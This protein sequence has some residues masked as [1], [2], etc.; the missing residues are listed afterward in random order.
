MERFNGGL[1]AYWKR[2]GA[3][4]RL[5]TP[6]GRR[7]RRRRVDRAELGEGGWRGVRIRTR[8]WRRL[9]RATPRRILAWI[10]DAYV[11]MMLALASSATVG[12]AYGVGFGMAP[13]KEYY[14]EKVLVEIYR[15]VLARRG[16]LAVGGART[17]EVLCCLKMAAKCI[18]GALVGTLVVAYVCDTVISDKK[19]FGGTTPKTISDKEWWEATD[20]KFQ[21]W[22]RTAGP[23]VVM[24]P[25]SRQNFIVKQSEA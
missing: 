16:I 4:E 23:P 13:V 21:A 17:D 2:R 14:D 18:T 24:N 12:G 8:V 15:T 20:K 3:Y 1:K 22:P 25:I 5:V 11:R 6:A 9:R 19:I 7:W 10:R